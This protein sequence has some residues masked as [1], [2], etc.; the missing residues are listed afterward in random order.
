VFL[1]FP[2]IL[3][4]G[5]DGMNNK[6]MFVVLIIISF[7]AAPAHAKPKQ[8]TQQQITIDGIVAKMKTQLEL[9][10][11]QV[12]DV[13]PIIEDFLDEEK[14]LKL[15]EKKHLSKVL[16]KDQLFTWDFLQN[17]KPRD[18]DKEKKKHSIF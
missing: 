14:Q 2:D 9:T 13:K 11:E 10:D 5:G 15:E 6:I 18:K 17:E 4:P 16:T 1:I 12:E 8:E 3:I 7:L